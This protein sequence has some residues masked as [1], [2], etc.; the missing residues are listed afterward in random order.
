M[1]KCTRDSCPT[2]TV[3]TVV[4]NAKRVVEKTIKNVL[5]QDY[6]N[7]EYIIV[8]GGSQDGTQSVIQKY[9]YGIHKYVSEPDKGIYDAMNKASNLASGTW[10]LYMNAGDQFYA[11]DSLSQL[12]NALSTDADVIFAGVVEILVD[13]YETRIFHEMPR[14]VEN[15]WYQ[16]P[17]SHQS[18]I[19]RTAV[20]QYYQFDACYRWCADHDMIARMYRDGK[21]FL[22]QNVLLSVFDCSSNNAHRDPQLYIRERWQ[23]SVGLVPWPRRILRY[24]YE[25]LHCKVWGSIVNAIKKVL[26]GSVILQLR[27]WRGTANS[28]T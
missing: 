17:T 22:S 28:Q 11:P 21:K 5:E 26:P 7:L 2:V 9:S 8:D 25:W 20:Q 16:M 14:P 19:V 3:I 4:L 10:V 12:S 23:L 15:I 13:G 27:R 18:T 6:P 1:C 24:G